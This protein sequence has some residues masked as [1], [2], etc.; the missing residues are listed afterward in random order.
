VDEG[1]AGAF[2]VQITPVPKTNLSISY[3]MSGTAILNTDYTLAGTPGK[4]TF[5]AGQSSINILF[6]ALKDS[7]KEGDET[8]IMTIPNGHG[9]TVQAQIIIHNR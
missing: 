7:V 1:K 5:S 6:T 3:S 4:A 8:A 2:K 9:G